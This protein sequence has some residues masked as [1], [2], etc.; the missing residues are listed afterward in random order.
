MMAEEP[1]THKWRDMDSD[2]KVQVLRIF[3]LA[4]GAT[5]KYPI[6]LEDVWAVLGFATKARAK[7]TLGEVADSEFVVKK[8]A[9]GMKQDVHM[10]VRAF[11]HL[12]KSTPQTARGKGVI[13]Y[14]SSLKTTT[15]KVP[16]AVAK[17]R[18]APDAPVV[19]PEKKRLSDLA[20][21]IKSHEIELQQLVA[22]HKDEKE[23]LT[24]I[25]TRIQAK[26]V[27]RDG[28]VRAL[29]RKIEDVRTE[30]N[31]KI[32]GIEAEIE[33]TRKEA[34]P[35]I[36]E[37]EAECTECAE[38]ISNNEEAQKRTQKEIDA[39]RSSYTAMVDSAKATQTMFEK[40]QQKLLKEVHGRQ[41]AWLVTQKLA[42]SVLTD[43]MEAYIED[44]A[45]QITPS[46]IP[47]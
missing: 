12:C 47:K 30:F 25:H 29:R 26:I 8:P 7:R 1:S 18:P 39:K 17:K 23:Q 41:R 16:G 40:L 21:D 2:A 4:K 36:V 35:K 10:T 32:A 31:A 13:D 19:Q 44:T 24:S 5:E 11:M 37:M 45:P 38:R 33:E 3:E 43:E 9:A 42:G 6:P 15:A 14:F 27:E 22:A 20:E 34:K 28:V 46:G